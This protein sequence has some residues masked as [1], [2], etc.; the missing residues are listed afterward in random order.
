M[1]E[2]IGTYSGGSGLLMN[3]IKAIS[4][5]FTGELMKGLRDGYDQ[6]S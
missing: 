1:D 2:P 3:G 5:V 6:P 4:I